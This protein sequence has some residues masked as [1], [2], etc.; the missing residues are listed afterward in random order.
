MNSSPLPHQVSTQL[1]ENPE[2]ALVE[3]VKHL[4]QHITAM[5]M[6]QIQIKNEMNKFIDK[7]KESGGVLGKVIYVLAVSTLSFV[8][9]YWVTKTTITFFESDIYKAEDVKFSGN[10][11]WPTV[12]IEPGFACFNLTALEEVKKVNDIEIPKNMKGHLGYSTF[13]FIPAKNFSWTT[14]NISKIAL[15][16]KYRPPLV[17][18]TTKCTYKSS[19]RNATDCYSPLLG[20]WDSY[21]GQDKMKQSFTPVAAT[22]DKDYISL[23]L[24]SA[25]CDTFDVKLHPSVDQ[26]LTNYK[27]FDSK[28]YPGYYKLDGIQPKQYRGYVIKTEEENRIKRRSYPCVDDKEYSKMRCIERKFNQYKIQ[29]VGC[30]LPVVTGFLPHTGNYPECANKSSVEKMIRLNWRLKFGGARFN[31]L[32]EIIADCKD[33]CHTKTYFKASKYGV[34]RQWQHESRFILRI[35][36]GAMSYKSSSEKWVMTLETFV[37]NVGGVFGL[38]LGL[39]GMS[40]ISGTRTLISWLAKWYNRFIQSS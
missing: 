30:H 17:N 7:K 39:S 15:E 2:K 19:V 12:T 3:R 13:P 26:I 11:L 28:L 16:T 20:K 14:A 36:K 35:Q 1:V 29:Q 40:V 9:V 33:A 37:A 22:S 5:S 24:N 6:S 31:D 32:M 27:V 34:V 23:T 8:A 25:L 38:F 4:E 10:F 21:E 18:F